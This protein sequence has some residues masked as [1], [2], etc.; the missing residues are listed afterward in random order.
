[1]RYQISNCECHH[2][3]VWSWRSR[4]PVKALESSAIQLNSECPLSP[5]KAVIAVFDV[6]LAF[7]SVQPFLASAHLG[8]S[9]RR[10]SC[11][12]FLVAAPF[13][14]FM[15]C[16]PPPPPPFAH[17]CSRSLVRSLSSPERGRGRR[18]CLLARRRRSRII[19]RLV[20]GWLVQWQSRQEFLSSATL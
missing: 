7:F 16:L 20:V 8:P 15:T 14:Q 13:K 5:Y 9:V 1:M 17:F 2:V 4:Q 11:A 12:A 10:S 18:G 6:A 19:R 3:R